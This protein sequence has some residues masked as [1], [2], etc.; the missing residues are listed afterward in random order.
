VH[1]HALT[2]T[3]KHVGASA[4]EESANT[5]L[6]GDLN[7][8]V[9][10]AVVQPLLST[11]LHHK[12]TANSVEGVGSNAGGSDHSLFKNHDS[13]ARSTRIHLQ[14]ISQE[15]KNMVKDSFKPG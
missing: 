2:S 9:N 12:T 15:V 8:A 1:C 13:S 4:L 5:L 3:T 14:Q 7:E 6:L 11:R 10:G